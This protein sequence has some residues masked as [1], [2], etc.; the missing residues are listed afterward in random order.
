MI[1]KEINPDQLDLLADWIDTKYPND[2]NPEVQSNLRSWAQSIRKGKAHYPTCAAGPW[3][4]T[5]ATG[6]WPYKEPPK[7]REILGQY[8]SLD[9]LYDFDSPN[10]GKYKQGKWEFGKTRW[11]F[12]PDRWAEI[13]DESIYYNNKG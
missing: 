11:D 2:Y 12:P 4:Y 10:V 8:Y 6:P 13:N 9:D 7:D 3:Q 5:C 1:Y